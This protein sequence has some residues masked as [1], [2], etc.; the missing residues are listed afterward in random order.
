MVDMQQVALTVLL[1]IDSNWSPEL[2]EL[3]Y[4]E[5]FPDFKEV[6]RALRLMLRG[7]LPETVSDAGLGSAYDKLEAQLQQF[8]QNPGGRN[9]FNFKV[10][11]LTKADDSPD[12]EPVGSFIV[13][14]T[15]K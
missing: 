8:L 6:I 5:S 9:R 15:I 12:T 2:S 14:L 3:I 7:K 11:I 13:S 10:P 1:N 4:A